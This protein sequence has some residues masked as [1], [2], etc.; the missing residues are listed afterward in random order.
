MRLVLETAGLFYP[1]L[2]YYLFHLIHGTL[3]VV[4]HI[5]LMTEAS[6]EFFTLFLLLQFELI[7]VH[8]Q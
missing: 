6:H 7:T 3:S 5:D 2:A 8:A 4:F 1:T